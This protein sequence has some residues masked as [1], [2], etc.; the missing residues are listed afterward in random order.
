MRVLPPL[1]L[2][3]LLIGSAHAADPSE[4]KVATVHD[5]DTFEVIIPDLPPKLQR[6]GIRVR[7]VDTPEMAGRAKCM[8]ERIM[9]NQAREF[10]IAFLGYGNL[11]LE[12]LAWDKHGGRIDTQVL[13]DG[14]DLAPALIAAGPRAS[15]QRRW[16]A[17]GVV[18]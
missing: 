15:V 1:F 8:T 16:E 18:R 4:W 14:K 7:G 13:V 9:A 2:F 3:G 5:G 6:V 11:Q 17:G 12:D 10:T